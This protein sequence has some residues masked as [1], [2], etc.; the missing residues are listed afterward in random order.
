MQVAIPEN[1]LL[2]GAYLL[3][4]PCYD[5]GH[6]GARL[7]DM[8]VLRGTGTSWMAAMPSLVVEMRAVDVFLSPQDDGVLRPKC[9]EGGEAAAWQD[10]WD[11]CELLR[12]LLARPEVWSE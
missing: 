6:K 10:L 11:T 12:L 5:S 7:K 1:R 2:K 8:Q 4:E 9:P 3:S